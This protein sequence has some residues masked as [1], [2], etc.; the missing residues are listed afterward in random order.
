MDELRNRTRKFRRKLLLARSL[1]ESLGTAGFPRLEMQGDADGLKATCSTSDEEGATRFVVAI[2]PLVNPTSDI[3]IRKLWEDAKAAEPELFAQIDCLK[4]E[5]A[6]RQMRN[7]NPEL[8]VDGKEVDLQKQYKLIAD[9]GYFID[10]PEALAEQKALTSF[11]LMKSILSAGFYQFCLKAASAA[12]ELDAIFQVARRTGS[13][14][15]YFGN[16]ISSPK[17]IYCLTESGKFTSEE[18]IIPESIGQDELVL[19]KGMVC[20]ACNNGVLAQLDQAFLHFDLIAFLRILCTD[21]A[22]SGALPSGRFQNLDFRKK[23][24]R[25]LV[26]VQKQ[27]KPGLEITK[28]HPDGSVE[29]K[30]SFRGKRFDP[31]SRRLLARSLHKMGLGMVALDQGHE[32]ALSSRY[33]HARSVVLGQIQYNGSFLMRVGAPVPTLQVTWQPFSI[34]TC[35]ILDIFGS[36]FVCNI[37]PEPRMQFCDELAQMGFAEIRMDDSTPIS[38]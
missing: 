37:E 38:L 14:Q 5:E 2:R 9:A 4:L 17:C 32:V 7:G 22:K 21:Q 25:E 31:K 20:D 36:T 18:H 19:P 33:D 3:E 28:K 10:D 12:M 13:L 34:G 6:L 15:C 23:S 24:P 30:I 26:F 16:A 35:L 8:C 1:L 11:P 27:G 29:F